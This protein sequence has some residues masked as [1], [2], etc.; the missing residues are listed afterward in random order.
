MA[1]AFTLAAAGWVSRRSRKVMD[2]VTWD[3]PLGRN[4][5]S[6]PFGNSALNAGSL[7]A[8]LLNDHRLLR[9]HARRCHCL[10]GVLHGLK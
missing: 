10:Q 3:A 1:C 8:L 6:S 4:S 5:A 9:L 7:V 2:A